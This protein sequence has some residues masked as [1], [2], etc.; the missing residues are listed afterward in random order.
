MFIDLT[1]VDCVF[2]ERCKGVLKLVFVVLIIQY[3]Q[4]DQ[5]RTEEEIV[6]FFY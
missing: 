2:N 1:F 5:N 4:Y 6:A 3:D